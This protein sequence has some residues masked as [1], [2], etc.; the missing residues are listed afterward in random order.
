M[1]KWLKTLPDAI[2]A[3]LLGVLLTLAFAPYEIFPLA[4]IT[5]A[6]L[7]ALWTRAPS[8]KRAFWLGF[9]FGLGLFGAGVYWVFISIHVIGEVP[10]FFSVVI[11]AG[12]IAFLSLYPG[13]VGYFINRY[14][15]VNNKAK[16]IYA[17]PAIWVLSE[18]IRSF[19]LTGFPWFFL[20]YS[21]T[22]SALRGYAPILGVY[23][24]SMAVA[25]SSSLILN[26]VIQF[27][28]KEYRSTYYNLFAFLTIWVLG[29]LL[30]L[31]PWTKA[32]G[33]PISVAL[34]QGNIAQT[35]KWS[36]EHLQLS[37]DRYTELT[38]PLLGKY[39]LIIWPES[40]IPMPL[41]D[42][43]RF[44]NTMD[45][46]VKT[47]GSQLLLGIPIRSSDK[48]GFYNAV[49]TLGGERN[50]Y[51]KRRL[52]PFG[53]YTP[54]LNIFSSAFNFM[55]IPISE[56]ISGSNYQKPLTIDDTK[57]LASICYEIAF[58]ELIRTR[59]NTIGLLLTVTNDAWFGESN[60][61]AQH[62][63]MAQMRAQELGRPLLFVSNDGITA[64]IG[65]SGRIESSLPPRQVTV[66]TGTVQPM[67]GTTPWMTNGID[68]ILF[69]IICFLVMAARA[70]RKNM[71][72]PNGRTI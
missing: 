41:Q 37:F 24:V 59:D 53:E 29:G 2:L 44:I 55:N 54:F 19:L 72:E 67:Q 22:N 15:P 8:P 20:G 62:L 38:Q 28:Q 69:A 65:A 50:V 70:N 58:P 68:P 5:M 16:L 43:E 30:S 18:W 32:Q 64:I 12:M 48:P 63:Q 61:Q 33:N 46:K 6:G 35:I 36:P 52:V 57:I 21:Q 56:M 49:V 34:V 66:L 71:R 25:L 7:L 13:L 23:G 31:I 26:A 27:K 11:T 60:A 4:I 9:L 47:S 40:A 39:R 14:F 51:L 1:K 45:A 42:A 17:F 3:F 10:K